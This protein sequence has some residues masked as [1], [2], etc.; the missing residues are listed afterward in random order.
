MTGAE[1]RAYLIKHTKMSIHD[2]DKHLKEGIFVYED[3]L[4]GYMRF[5]ADCVGGLLDE[6]EI[7][8]LWKKLDVIGAYRMEFVL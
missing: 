3:S 6:E 4:N 1:L 7:P 8:N 5:K 2:I